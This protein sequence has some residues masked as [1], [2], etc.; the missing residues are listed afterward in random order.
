M[1]CRTIPTSCR[2]NCRPGRPLGRT[3]RRTD[4]HRRIYRRPTAAQIGDPRDSHQPESVL[5]GVRP[6][7]LRAHRDSHQARNR[8]AARARSS[9]RATTTSSIP[10]TRSPQSSRVSQHPVQRHRQRPD[11]EDG[12]V[13]LQR[14]RARQPDATAST[15]SR[16]APFSN[17]A[18]QH[19]FHQPRH[20]F[21]AA[22]SA[23]RPHLEVS[24]RIDLQ[25][26]QKNTLTVALPV[27]AQQRERLLIGSTSLPSQATSSNSTE[28]AIQS[29]ILRSSTI[30]L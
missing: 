27:R 15:P 13:L 14:G 1:R 17:A 2:T 16:M 26:G 18:Q 29:A 5:R 11:L 6:P 9:C 3:E 24:P 21:R 28:N 25:L 12:F 19:V 23:R 20:P 22:S 30:T 8:Q 10:A 4:L 7:G